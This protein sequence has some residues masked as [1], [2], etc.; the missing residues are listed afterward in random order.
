MT[1][2]MIDN[3]LKIIAFILKNNKIVGLLMIK[4]LILTCVESENIRSQLP[5]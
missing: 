4:R 2:K 5:T 1:K 3:M